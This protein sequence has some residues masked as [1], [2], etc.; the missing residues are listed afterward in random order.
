VALHK[1]TDWSTVEGWKRLY[2]FNRGGE[3]CDYESVR[4]RETPVL[5]N[6]RDIEVRATMH[7]LIKS[8]KKVEQ[9]SK[10]KLHLLVLFCF[11][12]GGGSIYLMASAISNKNGKMS[13]QK[14]SFPAYAVSQHSAASLENR[15][16]LTE[17][18]HQNIERFKHYMDTLQQSSL[19]RLKYDSIMKLRP[20]LMDSIF[21]IEHLYHEQLK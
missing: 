14:I 18:E 13:I 16:I 20:G 9:S 17:S 1:A 4:F 5:H 10:V 2:D 12:F 15:Y 6:M 7:F 21:F 19:G 11:L 3:I 8:K